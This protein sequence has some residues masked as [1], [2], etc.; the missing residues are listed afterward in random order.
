M[1]KIRLALVDD[2]IFVR[3]SIT[4]LFANHTQIELVGAASCGEELLEN[5]ISWHPE[6]V[7]LDL[8][9]PGMGGMQTLDRIVATSSARVILFSTHSSKDASITLEAL[10]RGAADYVDKQQFSLADFER[11]RSVLIEKIRAVTG[12]KVDAPHIL[13][14]RRARE[15]RQ[16]RVGEAVAPVAK[17]VLPLR[18]ILEV[19]PAACRLVVLGASTGGPPALRKVLESLGGALPVP[20]A[21]VQHMANPFLEAFAQRLN[22]YVSSR[23]CTVSHEE[24][25]LPGYVYLAPPEVHFHIRSDGKSLFAALSKEPAALIH[26]PSVDVLF[27]SAA[28]AVGPA[29]IAALL[30]GMGRDGAQG[31]L[32]LAEAGAYTIA[33]SA[34]TCV[35][36]GMPRVAVE[37][38]AVKEVLPLNSIGPRIQNLILELRNSQEAN[39]P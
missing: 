8:Y 9:M 7:L 39:R 2:S 11:L 3:K 1:T 12:R 5:W 27:E 37:L 35:V 26:C 36:Y 13:P 17:R 25:L 34:E 38:Q 18:P 19:A 6:V 30:T 10:D 21:I 14:S 24:E 4:R 16:L 28:K 15:A 20:V 22:D 31:M 23:V 33:Q 29:A 32:K